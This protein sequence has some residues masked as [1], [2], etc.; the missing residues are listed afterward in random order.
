MPSPFGHTLAGLAVA[1][2]LGAP[3]GRD[4]W[5]TVFLANVADV[6]LLPGLFGGGMGPDAEHGMATHSLGAALLTGTLAGAATRWRGGRFGPRFAQATTAYASHLFLDYLG[7]ESAI[8]DGMM[9]FWPV[10]RRRIASEH[11]WFRTITSKSRKRG[12]VLGLCNLNNVA[13]LLG[14]AAVLG[15]ALWLARRLRR[16][17]AGYGLAT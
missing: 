15:P 1:S 13:A 4:G 11:S 9:L 10:S 12:F 14:E 7:K 8:G 3:S 2:L 5:Q 16:V 17:P 6:D